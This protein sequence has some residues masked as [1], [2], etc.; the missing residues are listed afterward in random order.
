[1]DPTIF[2]ESG[3]QSLIRVG[4]PGRPLTVLREADRTRLEH[5]ELATRLRSLER[6]AILAERDSASRLVKRALDETIRFLRSE[7]DW[8][9]NL[10][11]AFRMLR[12]GIRARDWEHTDDLYSYMDDIWINVGKLR[13]TA[14]RLFH[15]DREI[16][17]SSSWVWLRNYLHTM[18]IEAICSVLSPQYPDS[19]PNW[20]R[21]GA[22][23]RTRTIQWRTLLARA[24]LLAAA[25]LRA[26][27]REDDAFRDA[28]NNVSLDN[29][30]FGNYDVE[31]R[32]RFS[33]VRRFVEICRRHGDRPWIMSP[34]RLFLCTRP[35][36]YFDVAR[37]VLYHT[38]T[39]LHPEIFTELLEMVNAIRGTQYADPVGEVID[40]HTVYIPGRA[41]TGDDEFAN[42]Q[43]ILGNLVLSEEFFTRA[44]TRKCG[45]NTGD[46][47]LTVE[48]LR[49]LTEILSKSNELA[50]CHQPSPSLLVLPELS[51][52]RAWFREVATHVSKYG[53]FGLIVGLEYLH[54]PSDRSVFNQVY[55]VIPGPFSS[56]ATWPWT[57]EFPAREE[58]RKLKEL[59]V[60]FK[61]RDNH[62]S[63]P[64]TVVVS[65]Y[66][67][68]SVLICS[69][70]IEA[71]R[72]SDLAGR[73][74]VV[75]VPAW[76]KDT[77]SYDH[78]IQSTGLQLN[79][80]VGVAN[81]GHYSDC[82]AWAPKRIRWERDLC[83]LVER[84]TNGVIAVTLPLASLREWRYSGHI[85]GLSDDSEWRPLPPDWRPLFEL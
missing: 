26:F 73:V 65:P 54:S 24:R 25:D 82:R 55:A 69:E 66:G 53:R 79:A 17:S 57:K 81:N 30:G 1:M 18:R 36:S 34:P 51:L 70:L 40:K 67:H 35:P 8:V 39:G 7:D 43:L 61:K 29:D 46:P 11:V 4:P 13:A 63:R 21:D 14:G 2:H 49:D 47:V 45:S 6:A 27:D 80:I 41:E 5:F 15:R 48:R 38:E 37:R 3:Q 33:L 59:D 20:L 12:L 44:A 52:P 77:S 42:P 64:R 23:D 32:Q 74:E 16:V 22:V 68:I 75:A 78:L 56:T 71:Y 85:G 76:N 83:R 58:F 9:E 62:E 19:P 50:Q 72:I 28:P 31:L 84:D 60:S 10:D